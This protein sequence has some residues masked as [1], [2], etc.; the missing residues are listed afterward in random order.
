[1]LNTNIKNYTIDS[2]WTFD[3]GYE[4]GIKKKGGEWVI[5]ERYQTF[6]EMKV[7]HDKWCKFCETEPTEVYSVQSDEME[8]L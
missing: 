1:M 3:A 5:V 8:E 2:C 4:T 7:G 6:E